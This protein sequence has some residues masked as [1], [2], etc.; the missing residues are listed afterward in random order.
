MMK[1]AGQKLPTFLIES[2]W[3][4]RYPGLLDDVKNILVGGHGHIKLVLIL[5]W[6]KLGQTGTVAGTAE[7]WE[8]D[9]TTMPRRRQREV[10]LKLLV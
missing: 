6:E 9:C 4:E 3:S 8:L 10:W 7:L 1:I 5:V 2:E